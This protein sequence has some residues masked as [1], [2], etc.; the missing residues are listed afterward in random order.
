[1]AEEQSALLEAITA[2]GSD[3]K[4]KLLEH[5]K[6]RQ[7]I[8]QRWVKDMYQYRNQYE[9]SVKTGKSKVFVGYTRS[10]TDSW[11]AQMTDM[12]FPSDDKNYGISPTPMPDIANLAKQ[13]D[14][15]D[16]QQVAQISNARALMKRAKESAEAMEKLIDDQLLECDYAAEARL[17]LHYAAVLGTG[18]LRAPVV[19]VVESKAWGQDELG[20]WVGK[21]VTKTIPTA[22]LVLPWDFV[23]DMT[24]AT[25]KDCQFVF[26]RSYVTKKQLQTLAKNPYYLKQNVLELCELEGS[27]MRT[28]SPDMDGY[29]DT[30]RT[31]SGLETQSKD[32]RYELWTYHGGIPLSVLESANNQLGE[33]SQ[34]SIPDDEESRAANLEIDGVIVMA[35][36]GTILSCRRSN[37]I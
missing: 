26:E 10:K 16:P 9:S 13:P 23:P 15:D 31:L 14:S 20:Q 21:I 22:R 11:T 30:L 17:C 2:F 3:L 36:N 33:D 6:Q 28:A 18:I 5:L 7:P 8:V 29:V 12:L 19:D 35:G 34:L 1:M 25:I 24:A 4:S 27:D 37:Q 32:N